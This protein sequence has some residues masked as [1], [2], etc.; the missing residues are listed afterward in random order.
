MGDRRSKRIGAVVVSAALM[1]AVPAGACA[2]PFIHHERSSADAGSG[3]GPYANPL[4][5]G[6]SQSEVLRMTYVPGV[7]GVGVYYTTDGTDPT[8]ASQVP[9][10]TT[11]YIVS[12]GCAASPAT[13]GEL[14]IPGQAE[15]TQLRYA[16]SGTLL[17]TEH[18]DSAAA[19]CTSIS[20][21][22]IYTYGTGPAPP[23]NGGG[24]GTTKPSNAFTLSKAKRNARKGTAK[25]TATVPGAGTVALLGRGVKPVIKGV[26]RATK[27][28]LLV[29][30]AGAKRKKL[31]AGKKVKLKTKVAFTPTGGDT[32]VKRR[33]VKL[34]Y[35]P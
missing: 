29:R 31:R 14:S 18:F 33:A 8:G 16:V 28:K 7:A 30:A 35:S 34:R 1:L 26:A 19:L 23:A 5:P 15:N 25:M 6:A 20:C 32:N 13:I 3:C 27:V 9:T 21:A 22:T 11:H 12:S 10:G 4:A 2:D 17:I 24:G